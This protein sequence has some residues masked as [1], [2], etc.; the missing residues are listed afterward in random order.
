MSVVG[1]YMVSSLALRLLLEVLLLESFQGGVREIVHEYLLITLPLVSH[2]GSPYLT[3]SDAVSPPC[4][5]EMEAD[6]A[7]FVGSLINDESR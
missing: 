4:S 5:P 1:F 3:Q 2:D 7:L 6:G